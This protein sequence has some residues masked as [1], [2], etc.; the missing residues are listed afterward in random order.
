MA[1]NLNK[2]SVKPEVKREIDTV[3]GHEQRPVYEIV[4]EAWELYKAVAVGK[5]PRKGKRSASVSVV[6]VIS[7]NHQYSPE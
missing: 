5:S 1:E 6:D 7:T 2:I 3:A 4:G